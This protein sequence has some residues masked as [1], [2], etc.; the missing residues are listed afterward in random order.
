[1]S[2]LPK[3]SSNKKY[4]RCLNRLVL[5]CRASVLVVSNRYRNTTDASICGAV[6]AGRSIELLRTRVLGSM[7]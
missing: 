7:V 1:M 3:F 5:G 2:K 6:P 4:W